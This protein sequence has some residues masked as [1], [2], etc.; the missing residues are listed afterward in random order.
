MTDQ[1]RQNFNSCS[2]PRTQKIFAQNEKRTID[3]FLGFYVFRILVREHP[4]T[5]PLAFNNVLLLPFFI[6]NE[7]WYHSQSI[8]M[9]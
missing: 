5:R 6:S 9:V 7:Y 8:A 4:I 2:L 3:L 1:K